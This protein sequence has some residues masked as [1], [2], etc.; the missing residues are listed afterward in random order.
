MLLFLPQ[1]FV[2]SYQELLN[3]IPTEYRYSNYNSITQKFN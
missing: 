1:F 3:L 2:K